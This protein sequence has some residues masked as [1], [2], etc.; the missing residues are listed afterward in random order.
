MVDTVDSGG[1]RSTCALRL[2]ACLGRELAVQET[3][4]ITLQ[5]LDATG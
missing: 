1:G 3:N 2:A 5:D 4:G